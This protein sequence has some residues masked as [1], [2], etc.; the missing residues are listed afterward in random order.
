MAL[1]GKVLITTVPFAEE[2]R[3]PRELLDRARVPYVVNPIGRRFKEE[4]LRE[5]IGGFS[6][7]IAGTEPITARVMNAAPD[8][9]LIARVGI[10]LD[11]VDLVHARRQGITVTYTPDAPAPA[12]AELTI[13]LMLS[14]LRGVHIAD[15][16]MHQGQ[17]KRVAGRRVSC[18][19]IG[20]IGAGRVGG[21]V[22]RHLLGGF[23]GVRVMANDLVVPDDMSANAALSWTTKEEIYATADIVSVH[24]PLQPSTRYLVGTKELRMMRPGSFLINTA[25]GGIVDEA[26][27]LDALR[28]KAIAGAA[29]DVF[30]Q[31]PY[32]GPLASSEQCVLLSHMGSMSTDCRERMELEATEEILRAVRGEE[33]A[34]PVPECEYEMAKGC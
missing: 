8:L 31:E 13:G 19:T 11:N 29:L 14:L 32:S 17:W 1:S 2:N 4:E 15:R 22:I 5:L 18:A 23:E 34:R 21:R 33:P 9:K 28:D 10:G 26:A 20:V 16:L 12:V 30:E 7:M 27:L 25:R 24:V 3:V 6:A